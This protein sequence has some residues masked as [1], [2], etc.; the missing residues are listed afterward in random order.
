MQR[1][2]DETTTDSSPVVVPAIYVTSRVHDMVAVGIGLHL[3]FG[4]AMSWPDVIR[5][6]T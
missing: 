3:P 6:P 5:R 4:L 1:R 2:S